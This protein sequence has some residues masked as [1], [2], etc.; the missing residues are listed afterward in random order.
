MLYSHNSN[1]QKSFILVNAIQIPVD[2][3]DLFLLY[4]LII[5]MRYIRLMLQAD[6]IQRFDR[7]T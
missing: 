5:I 6:N 1:L 3:N 2:E 7:W 4:P